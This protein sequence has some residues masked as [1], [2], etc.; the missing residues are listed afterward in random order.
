MVGMMVYRLLSYSL[1]YL[2]ILSH[3]FSTNSSLGTKLDSQFLCDI[4]KVPG[5]HAFLFALPDLGHEVFVSENLDCPVHGII[6]IPR[7]GDPLSLML[8]LSRHF[9]HNY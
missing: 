8:P 6:F 9:I 2:H 5:F 4:F 3:T 7:D 1:F